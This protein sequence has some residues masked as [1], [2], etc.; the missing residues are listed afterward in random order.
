MNEPIKHPVTYLCILVLV[1]SLAGCAS[2]G[3]R[4]ARQAPNQNAEVRA[5]TPSEPGTYE[6]FGKNYRVLPDSHGYLEIGIAS[7][8]G[9]KFHGK[10]TANGERYDMYVPSAAHRTLPLPTYVKVT[11]L[12]NQR[13]IIVR[14]NDRGPFHSDRLI[15]LSYKAALELGFVEAGTA[16]VVVEA[17]DHMNYPEEV[18]A[19]PAQVANETEHSFYLQLGAFAQLGGAER[20]LEE[21][22]NLMSSHQ[23]ANVGIRILSEA[24]ETRTLHKVWMGPLF[25]AKERDAIVALVESADLAKPIRVE[26]D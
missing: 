12:N 10:L 9:R 23:Y 3:T 11:N 22:R 7:W 26:V 1:S 4:T 19:Q 24:N 17:V 13:R 15:D 18:K 21:T 8:Y 16:P 5:R 6:V 2:S 14:V 25:D 20:L